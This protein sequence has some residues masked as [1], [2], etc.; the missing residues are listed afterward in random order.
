[1]KNVAILL[2]PDVL[3]LDVAG[4][5]EVFSIANRYLAADQQYSIHTISSTEEA[6]VRASNGL[7]MLTDKVLRPKPS[8]TCCWFLADQVLITANTPNLYPGCVMPQRPHAVMVRYA[9]APSSSARP[10]CSMATR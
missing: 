3:L 9:P 5:M 8:S 2:F 10:A 6:Q 7:N 1:M 4:P